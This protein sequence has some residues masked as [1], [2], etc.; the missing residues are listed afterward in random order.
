MATAARMPWHFWPVAIIGILWN[1]FGA[2]D[3]WMSK[4]VGEPYYRQM[5]M[6]DAQIA[7]MDTFPTWMTA[8]WATG[9]WGGALGAVLLLLRSR[10]SVPVFLLSLAAFLVSLVYAYL[11]SNGGEVMGDAAAMQLV[12]LF[13]CLFFVVYSWRQAQLGVLR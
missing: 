7:Y 8:V 2:Y 3:Y 11:L 9:V 4:T 13:G 6:N 5:G 10:W 1:A 12:V